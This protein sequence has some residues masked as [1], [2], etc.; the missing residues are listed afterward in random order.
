MRKLIHL[1][2]NQRW[3]LSLCV[4]V[5]ICCTIRRSSRRINIL[6]LAHLSGPEDRW[7]CKNCNPNP[8]LKEEQ[9]IIYLNFFYE[10]KLYKEIKFVFYVAFVKAD[11]KEAPN[12]VGIMEA[13][14]CQT[15]S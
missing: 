1:D 14:K 13:F 7:S 5:R 10:G 12:F 8:I 6:S 2:C 15:D 9:F 3:Y 11:N 4:G